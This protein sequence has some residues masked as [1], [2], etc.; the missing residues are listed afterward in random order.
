MHR[1]FKFYTYRSR[2]TYW[3][4]HI[5]RPDL[6]ICKSFIRNL[7]WN[8]LRLSVINQLSHNRNVALKNKSNLLFSI[9][10]Q[11]FKI[12]AA[13][14]FG[15]DQ[16]ILVRL[17]VWLRKIMSL[18]VIGLDLFWQTV[19]YTAQI[20]KTGFDAPLA[21]LAEQLTLNQRV[22][23]SIPSRRI[24]YCYNKLAKRLPIDFLR[25]KGS[26]INSNI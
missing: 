4:L 26:V 10:L 11:V 5:F 16:S 18:F 9:K 7:G 8:I 13:D 15:Q 21:Q 1:S 6:N 12:C 2:D 19:Y 14:I 17:Q 25:V 20:L 24:Y 22:E 23:G 3:L